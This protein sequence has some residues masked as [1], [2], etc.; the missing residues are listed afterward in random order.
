[1]RNTAFQLPYGRIMGGSDVGGNEVGHAFSLRQV[2]F[3]VHKSPQGKLSGICGAGA[4]VAKRTDQPLNYILRTMQGK[5]NGIITRV[6]A[7]TPVQ[8]GYA[9]IN[10]AVTVPEASEMRGV[11]RFLIQRLFHQLS[12]Q[13]NG[14]GAAQPHHG[15]SSDTGRG[16]P[17]HDDIFARFHH[18]K[19]ETKSPACFACGAC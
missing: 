8:N 7:R 14:S 4:T 19:V 12:C 16:S 10:Q 2:E 1:M 11:G 13:F 9:F 17:G 5:L 15:H 18:A 3:A 6:A